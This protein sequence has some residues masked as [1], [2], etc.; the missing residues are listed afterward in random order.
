MHNG[1]T[2]RRREKG[3]EVIFETIITKNLSYLMSDIKPQMEEFQRTP[4]RIN[5]R[6]ATSRHI[7]FKVQK[8]KDFFK[9]SERSQRGKAPYLLEKQS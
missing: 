6:K 8:I 2:R 5:I 3:T 7:I 4:S 9:N 1:N